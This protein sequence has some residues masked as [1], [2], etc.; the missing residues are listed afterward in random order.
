MGV[1]VCHLRRFWLDHGTAASNAL[2]LRRVEDVILVYVLLHWEGDVFH[3]SHATTA[4][5]SHT[6][7]GYVRGGL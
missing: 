6:L 7:R 3:L 5:S 4:G 1:F 2:P